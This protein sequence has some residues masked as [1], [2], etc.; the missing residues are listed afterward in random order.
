MKAQLLDAWGGPLRYGEHRDP[1]AG[2]GE[3]LVAVRACG[4]GL[5]VVNYMGGSL[6]RPES[7]PRVPGHE[8]TGVVV[9]AGPGVTGLRP[10]DRVMSYFYLTCGRC[11]WCR[12]G[13]EPLCRSHGGYV[14]VHRDG[15]YAELVA[16][17]EANV[18]PLPDGVPFVGGTVIPDAVATPYHV[19]A[20]RAAVRPGDRVLVVGAAGGVGI[21]MT[22]MARLFGGRVVAVDVDDGKLE[23]CRRFG[24]DATVN[25]T[26]PDAHD[27]ARAALDDGATVAID[28][29]GSRETLAWTFGLLGPAARM[30]MLTTFEGA[31]LDVAPRQMVMGELTLL[32][33]RYCSRAEVLAAARLVRHG[34]ITPVVSEVRPLEDVEDLHGRL[35]ARSLFGRG[36]VMMEA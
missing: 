35:R 5:T 6:G 21:H 36:A 30:I 19:C 12:A 23:H 20:S 15:G 29:V 27:R 32:G 1:A 33:S 9:E 14:G 8:F 22:Q 18:L 26:A 17:P 4:V 10:G 25:I 24:A 31:G 7:L 28:L 11:E 34:Q 3:V 13:R 16:L 2:P